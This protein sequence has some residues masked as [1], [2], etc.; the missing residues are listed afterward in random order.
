M[1]HRNVA[2]PARRPDRCLGR[3]LQ[4]SWPRTRTRRTT[5][6]NSAGTVGGTRLVYGAWLALARITRVARALGAGAIHGA[7]LVAA[8]NFFGSVGCIVDTS[9]SEGAHRNRFS[10]CRAL[11]RPAVGGTNPPRPPNLGDAQ[12]VCLV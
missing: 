10:R 5:I 6:R 12:R 1:R 3:L 8:R 9:F 4:F 7:G 2:R 11:R